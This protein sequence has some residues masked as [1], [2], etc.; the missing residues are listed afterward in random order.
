MMY[1]TKSI[2]NYSPWAWVYINCASMRHCGKS[3]SSD[4]WK[5]IISGNCEQYGSI[6]HFLAET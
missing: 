5:A 2:I 3:D 1:F 4:K 6:Y